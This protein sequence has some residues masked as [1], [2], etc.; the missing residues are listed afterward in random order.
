M[1]LHETVAFDAF[2]E[3]VKKKINKMQRM[4]VD[5]FRHDTLQHVS[6]SPPPGVSFAISNEDKRRLIY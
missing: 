2:K 6:N 3:E 1:N 5:I 4:V